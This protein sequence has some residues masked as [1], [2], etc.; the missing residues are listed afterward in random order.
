MNETAED[1]SLRSFLLPIAGI[2]WNAYWHP[3]RSRIL[4][5][6]M[7]QYLYAPVIHAT[8]TSAWS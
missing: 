1:G 5:V 7:K 3:N 8:K 2:V 4:K 6:R